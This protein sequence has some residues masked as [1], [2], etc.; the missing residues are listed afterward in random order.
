MIAQVSINSAIINTNKMMKIAIVSMGR[1]HLINLARILSQMEDVQVTFY[2]MIPKS[3]C[4]QFGYNGKVV[5]FLFP[6][7]IAF[8]LIEQIP[9]LK[10]YQRSLLRFLIR[11]YFDLFCAIFLRSCDFVVGI[12]GAAVK[13]SLKAKSKY[14]S[15]T[16]CD[17]GSSHIITQNKVHDS[18]SNEP[19][20]KW[21]T[22]YMLNH[23]NMVDYI[24]APSS[25]V[26]ETDLEHGIEGNRIYINPY[27]VNPDV[28]KPTLN[29]KINS[30]CYDVIMVGSW[31][32]HKGC[33]MLTK[34]CIEILGIKLLHVGTIIDCD[35]PKNHLFNH[36]DFVPEN[37]LTNFY[38]QAKVLVLPSLDEGCA[39]VQFQAIACGLPIVYSKN[40]GGADIKRLL[41]NAETCIE[42]L[43]PLSPE[44]ISDAIK[45]ALVIA[46]HLP[47]GD[48]FEHADVINNITWDAYGKRYLEILYQIKERMNK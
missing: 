2:T 26:K 40:T 32:K 21:N 12:N 44:T 30:N 11:K 18:Y 19:T 20:S 5:T 13:T 39:L 38:A 14:G 46:E 43:E 8:V 10:L 35:I 9:F 47:E 4:R 23:Y 6:L 24:I 25:Y 33:D 22:D 1:S 27:G 41:N 42:I 7:G 3:R 45:K 31:W 17:Q 15:I 36:V 37:Q 29:P 28:F 48:R 34:A 16:L